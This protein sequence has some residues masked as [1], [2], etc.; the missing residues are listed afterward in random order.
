MEKITELTF[1]NIG[2]EHICCAI[3]DKKS[4]NGVVCKK[5]W[6]MERM[7]EGLKFRKFAVRGKSFIEYLPAEYSWDVVK[8]DGYMYV[9]C[10]WVAGKYAGHGWGKLLLEE[11]EK[12][13]KDMNG[14]IAI[15]SLRKKPFLSDPDFLR[16]H[17]FEVCDE[18]PPYF[19]LMVKKFKDVPNPKFNIDNVNS[20][21]PLRRGITV[22]YTKQCPF[23]DY[24]V[25]L[26]GRLSREE[27]VN[28]ESVEFDSREIAQKSPSP[29]TTFALYLNGEFV[30]HELMSENKFR[31]FLEDIRKGF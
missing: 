11:C 22:F 30:N 1:E 9:N 14:I 26:M 5:K 18:Y 23:T 2:D 13:S 8:A 16:K 7:K 27:N 21:K 28:F 31:K 25:D 20:V 10:F 24:Y 15:S 29:K 3:S 6:L 19:T 12:D 4:Q 17:G